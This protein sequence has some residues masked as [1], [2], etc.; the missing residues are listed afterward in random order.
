MGEGYIV[1]KALLDS[2][3]IVAIAYTESTGKGRRVAIDLNERLKKWRSGH[4]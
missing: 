4:E 3:D 1:D 2:P